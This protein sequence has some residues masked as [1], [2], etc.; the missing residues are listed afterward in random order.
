MGVA[1]ESYGLNSR[2]AV[3]GYRP[4]D[5]TDAFG[6]TEMVEVM[7]QSSLSDE[8]MCGLAVE[9]ATAAAGRLP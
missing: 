1:R 6:G 8:E 2:T 9:L 5:R 7:A 3:I 4:L